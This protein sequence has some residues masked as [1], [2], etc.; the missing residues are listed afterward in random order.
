VN[1]TEFMALQDQYMTLVEIYFA[2]T[3]KTSAM[4][5]TCNLEP[6]SFEERFA[7]LSQEIIERDAHLMY[8]EAKR[9]LHNAARLG[10]GALL[11]D[12]LPAATLTLLKS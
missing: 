12:S 3:R 2:E 8:M 1:Q 10:Y 5:K 4:L 9:F 7:V 11:E 6:L